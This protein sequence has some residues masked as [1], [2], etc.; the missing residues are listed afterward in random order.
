MIGYVIVKLNWWR[1]VY[2]AQHAQVATL[3]RL[4]ILTVASLQYSHLTTC[5][6]FL[7]VMSIIEPQTRHWIMDGGSSSPE[8][9]LVLILRPNLWSSVFTMIQ[10]LTGLQMSHTVYNQV[11]ICEFR[12]TRGALYMPS[13]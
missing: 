11:K 1:L 9:M 10:L 4:S 13:V 5:C 12:L 8:F 3:K 6:S 2:E 7:L